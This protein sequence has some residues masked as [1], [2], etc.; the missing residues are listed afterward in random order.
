MGNTVLPA[1]DTQ[2]QLDAAVQV[3]SSHA[4]MGTG[5]GSTST[6]S[7]GKNQPYASNMPNT[8]PEAPMTGSTVFVWLS[9]SSSVPAAANTL[10]K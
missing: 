2:P 7:R 5:M 8:P 1:G 4:G 10:T 9:T 6:R 3:T